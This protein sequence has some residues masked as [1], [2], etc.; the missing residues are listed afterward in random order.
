MVKKLPEIRAA[1]A[2]AAEAIID[3]WAQFYKNNNRQL[4]SAWRSAGTVCRFSWMIG[5]TFLW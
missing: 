2:V 1:A 5:A 4:Q 3:R